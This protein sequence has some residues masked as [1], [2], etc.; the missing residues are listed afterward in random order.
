MCQFRQ[1]MTA[2]LA[3]LSKRSSGL[4]T[5]WRCSVPTVVSFMPIARLRAHRAERGRQVEI[6][7][8][9]M[10]GR[11][12]F[13]FRAVRSFAVGADVLS[14]LCPAAGEEHVRGS[15]SVAG[16]RSSLHSRSIKPQHRRAS[17]SVRRIA[18]DRG[19][20]AA[21]ASTAG[22]RAPEGPCAGARI[23]I[24]TIYAH[25]RSIKQKTGC[26]R[27]GELIRRLNDLQAAARS[28]PSG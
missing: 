4:P 9:D 10:A 20:G 23:S 16:C 17:N 13:D 2:P 26:H 12:A 6:A 3:R 7:T 22:R 8:R 5:A 24:N 11:A 28:E 18:I 14:F 27:M 19:R 1:P 21:G 25:L 15:S